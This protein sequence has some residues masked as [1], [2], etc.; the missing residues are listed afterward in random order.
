MGTPDFAVPCLE[1]LQQSHHSIAAVIT[2]PDKPAGRGRSPQASPVKK[3]ALE[4]GLP[5]H[6]PTNLKSPE[7]VDFFHGLG[8]DLNVVVAFR[9]LPEV[10]WSAPR[11]GTINLH[12][13]LL[14]AYRGAAPIQWAIA[15]GAEKTG[16]STFR[17]AHAIDTGDVLLQKEIAL[18]GTETG[19]SLYAQM[20][21]MGPSMLLETLDLLESGTF[22]ASPQSELAKLPH[23][24]PSEAPKLEKE[25]GCLAPEFSVNEAERYIRAF[26]PFPGTRVQLIMD[27]ESLLELKVHAA[28]WVDLPKML[29]G[30]IG[31]AHEEL[32][33]GFKDGVLRLTQVQAPGKKAMPASD[34][35]RGLRNRPVRWQKSTL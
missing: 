13:S 8:L 26:Y 25:H 2:A 24:S 23:R 28:E 22:Q 6:Q 21:H 19:G 35:L 17:L 31:I 9:M 11:L 15:R 16:L 12:A 18:N 1:A 27:D 20:M 10:I 5:V 29:P 33:L 30:S 4:L 32:F 7:F 14:P 3:K 34:F